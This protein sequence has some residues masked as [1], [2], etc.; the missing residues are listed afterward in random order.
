MMQIH[1][2]QRAK[3]GILKRLP[4]SVKKILGNLFSHYAFLFKIATR[5]AHFKPQYPSFFSS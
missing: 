5:K 2:K 4:H 1:A 3:K